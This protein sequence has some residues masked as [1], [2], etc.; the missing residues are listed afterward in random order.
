MPSTL[1]YLLVD[2]H[3]VLHAWPEL[4]RDQVIASKRHLARTALLKRLR[5][6]QDSSGS[7]VVVVFD[8]T[9]A[10]LSEERE[11][12]G[13]QII[14][15]DSGNS[16]D[17]LIEKLAA[18]YAKTHPMRVVSA[19]GMVGETV[20]AF[21]ADWISPD[22]LK[23]LCQEAEKEIQRH[24]DK[25]KSRRQIM[26]WL[27]LSGASLALP[28]CVI[29]RSQRS[30]AIPK[31]AVRKAADYCATRKSRALLIKQHG[32]IVHESYPN[33]GRKDEPYRIFSGTKAFWGLAA[34]VAVKDGLIHLDEKVAD[35]LLEWKSH[36]RKS[37]ITLKQLL[38]FTSGLERGLYLHED[39]L[40]DRNQL[41]LKRPQVAAPGKSFIYG[42]SQ[43]QVFHEILKQKLKES[44]TH[45]LE[46]QVLKPLG[47]GPQRYLPDAAGNPLLAAGFIMTARQWAKMG[48][49]LLEEGGAV[50]NP[51]TFD[52]LLQGSI[53]NPAY[54]FGFWN[55][56]AASKAEAREIDIEDLLEREWDRQSWANVCLCKDA[57]P[58][59]IA[60]I[61]SSYQ[62]LYVIPARGLVIVRMGQNADFSDGDFLRL[63][64]A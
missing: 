60:C 40:K 21:G 30:K 54:S 3:S 59:M 43:L 52:T 4:R 14:Y 5:D 39:G 32:H 62:R 50:L 26:A 37:Q 15:A 25:L 29:N 24:M 1:S 11:K 57:P 16:A 22:M 2:G 36:K 64:L 58:D 19:D 41:A 8:G 10:Q 51:S 34:M 35:S 56:R 48:D 27:G 63:I 33:A 28:G 45:Y 46:N 9:Q 55:N 18:K 49:L 53:A 13:L 7:Q 44:P 38:H 61:G 6:F 42:P 20:M 12:G 31:T 17:H 23:T 47:L